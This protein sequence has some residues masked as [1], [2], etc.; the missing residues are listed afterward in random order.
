MVVSELDMRYYDSAGVSPPEWVSGSSNQI[1][2]MG[3]IKK[4][5]YLSQ[6]PNLY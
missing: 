6:T 3:Y 4:E 5:G 1:G 2:S